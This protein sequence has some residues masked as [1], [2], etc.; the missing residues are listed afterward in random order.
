MLLVVL[1]AVDENHTPVDDIFASVATQP[2][3]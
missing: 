2:F 1:V 3:L